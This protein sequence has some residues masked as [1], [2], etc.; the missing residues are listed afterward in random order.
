MFEHPS[1]LHYPSGKRPAPFDYHM[2]DAEQ[3]AKKRLKSDSDWPRYYT[4][5]LDLS[6]PPDEYSMPRDGFFP[7]S[8]PAS[9]EQFKPSCYVA[10]EEAEAAALNSVFASRHDAM[11]KPELGL[12]IIDLSSGEELSAIAQSSSATE[13]DHSYF[14]SPSPTTCTFNL[15]KRHRDAHEGFSTLENPFD[16][17]SEVPDEEILSRPV[18]KPRKVRVE[19]AA[20][21]DVERIHPPPFGSAHTVNDH[22]TFCNTAQPSTALSI[23]RSQYANHTTSPLP[24]ICLQSPFALSSPSPSLYTC[25]TSIGTQL[26]L[27]N[28]PSPH[29]H[30]NICWKDHWT[31][32]AT[33]DD[34]DDDENAGRLVELVEDEDV[35]MMDVDTE[36]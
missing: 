19:P 29:S 20:Q 5:W 10:E 32:S 18:K 24:S 17:S 23:R 25:P 36:L 11:D 28:S 8:P 14:Q 1:S 22:V 2:D 12:R 13:D 3:Y 16:G 9:P 15:A 31:Y 30:V 4:E 21:N 26:V 35:K 33:G 27:Y 34:D 6:P 7:D